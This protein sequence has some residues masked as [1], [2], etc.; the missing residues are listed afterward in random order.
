MRGSVNLFSA[1]T[2]SVLIRIGIIITISVYEMMLCL[3]RSIIAVMC[4]GTHSS[5]VLVSLQL[6]CIAAAEQL[7]QV[8]SDVCS[9]V[10]WFVVLCGTA[11]SIA[12]KSSVA[13]LACYKLA[14]G[15]TCTCVCGIVLAA[16]RHRL[17]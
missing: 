7:S 10:E 3:Y 1:R 17:H 2:H 6:M 16:H 15:S 13:G 14:A 12:S 8:S 11:G 9:S 4:Q 5:F